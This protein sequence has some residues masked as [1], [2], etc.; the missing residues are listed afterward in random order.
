MIKQMHNNLDH[1]SINGALLSIGSIVLS[2]MTINMGLSLVFM[3]LSG[4]A[5]VTT[6][7]YNIKKIKEN[8]KS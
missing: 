2:N 8:E 7:I 3:A 1:N 4:V 5:S 6:I